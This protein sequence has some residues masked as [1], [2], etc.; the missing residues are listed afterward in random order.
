MPFCLQKC[1]YCDFFSVPY[2]EHIAYVYTD[3]V[4]RNAEHYNERYDSIYFGGGTPS[5]A[6]W[7]ICRVMSK[8]RFSDDA[9]VTVE[10]N[11]NT[12][13]KEALSSM[14]SSGINRISVGVQSFSNS[15]LNSLA[16]G[17]TSEDAQH[18]IKMAQECGFGNISVDLML[19]IPK[20]TPD[21][22]RRSIKVLANLGVQHVS[23]YML[24]V[25]PRTPF[26]H[27]NPVLPDENTVAQIYLSAA[28]ALEDAGFKQYE[29]SNFARSGFECKHNLKYWLC[30][31]YLGIG[32][33][34]HSYY[35]GERF[36]VDKNLAAFINAP[37]QEVVI[38][39][40]GDLS[41]TDFAMMKL[42]LTEGLRFTECR[43]FGIKKEDMLRRASLV[44]RNYL[45][46]TDKNVAITREGFLVSNQII[47]KLTTPVAQQK[48]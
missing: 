18:A 11:P 7:N 19:G 33:G 21:S 12:L 20:Q 47:G 9:E 40:S 4:I 8:L 28:G 6:W 13:T 46:V 23:A 24:K 14:K 17:H 38:T 3:A 43:R 30:E 39:D 5:L 45:D 32:T 29:I 44:P 26:A 42:R 16:R 31:E 37:L 48:V 10:A 34:A 35:G 1:P 41:F 15:E 36:C 25:E 2:N 22:I 27:Y